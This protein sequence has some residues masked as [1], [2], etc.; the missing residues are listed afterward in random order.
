MSNTGNIWFNLLLDSD[1]ELII[2]DFCFN[3]FK[4]NYSITAEKRT[5]VSFTMILH[6][7]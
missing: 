6:T 1:E 5:G 4:K 3:N 7:L 2:I